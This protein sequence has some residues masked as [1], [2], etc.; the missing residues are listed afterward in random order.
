MIRY[1]AAVLSS[2]GREILAALSVA[3]EPVSKSILYRAVNVVDEDPARETAVLIREHLVRY[4]GGPQGSKLEPFHDQVREAFLSWIGPEELRKWHSRLAMLL[5]TETGID[6]HRLLRHY[7]GAGNLPAAFEAALAAARASESAL[8]FQQAAQFY[9]EALD[10]GEA[11]EATQANLHRRRAEA[12]A[13]AGR[14]YESGYAYLEAARWPAW[15]NFVEMRRL[16]AEQLIRSGYLEEGTRLFIELLRSTGVHIP[17]SRVETLLR[18]LVLRAF[19]RLRGLRWRDDAEATTSAS[20]LQKL[21]LL[22]SGAMALVS[23]DTIFGSYLQALHMLAALRAGEPSRLC[24]SLSFA[25][26]YEC[27]GGTREYV[28]GRKLVN[29]AQQLA[30]RLA[31]P[32]LLPMT[33]GCWAGLDFLS[34]RVEDGLSHS[35]TGVEGL[36][37]ASRRGRAWELGTFNMLLIWFLGWAGKIRELSET[38]PLL[39]AEG[40]SRGDVYTEVCLRCCGTAHLIELAADDPDR[41]LAEIEGSIKRWR[42]TS[43]DLPHLYATFAKVECFLYADRAEDARQLLLSDWP[44]IRRSLFTRKSQIHR[45]I[46]FYLR[47]RTSLAGWLQQPTARELRVE[48]EQFATRLRKLDSRWADALSGLLRAGILTGFGRRAAAV[49]QLQ[50]AETALRSQGLNLLAAAVLRRQGELLN[51]TGTEQIEAADAFMRSENIV[52]PDRI[53]A[54]I[55]PGDWHFASRPESGVG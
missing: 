36:Q 9:A 11:D 22:W 30:R 16:A 28:H 47:G 10:T 23:I 13:R 5:Q 32:Y 27:M 35:R 45:T 25:A 53:T 51:D 17:A 41:A 50:T 8:A 54:M 26:V 37:A 31:D 18:M 43:Y 12:L 7:R 34:G 39:A 14:G 2:T 42:K 4:T 20:V 21:D 1:R 33:F 6:P 40:R 44:L 3:G 24:L 19:I 52:R 29:V 55:L 49:R 46:L 15:N 38:L 48:T